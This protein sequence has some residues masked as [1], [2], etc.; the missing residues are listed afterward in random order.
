MT[1]EIA[2]EQA[3]DATL[4]IVSGRLDGLTATTLDEKLAAS[5]GTTPRTII[6]MA[7]LGY[8]SSAGLRILL[9]A[10]KQAKGRGTW[11]A[12]CSLHPHVRE[13]FDVSGFSNIFTIFGAREEAMADDSHPISRS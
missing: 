3:A 7:G 2:T 8:V 10:A 1:I 11:L 4:V 6:D 12:L 9:K 13:V 5:I